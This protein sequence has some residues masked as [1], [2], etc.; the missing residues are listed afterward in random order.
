MHRVPRVSEDPRDLCEDD[1]AG[2]RRG[3][4]QEAGDGGVPEHVVH[5]VP[6]LG[7]ARRARHDGGRR[8]PA[9]PESP[10]HHRCCYIFQRYG[11]GVV[12]ATVD[13]RKYFRIQ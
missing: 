9:H 4:H 1:Q 10:Q 2:E 7:A 5:A 6:A 8:R 3:G 11:L 13:E 12:S